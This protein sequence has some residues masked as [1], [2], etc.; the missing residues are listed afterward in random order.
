MGVDLEK[1]IA[2]LGG[3]GNIRR[4]YPNNVMLQ[5]EVTN[6]A[7]VDQAGI[8]AATGTIGSAPAGGGFLIGPLR[9]AEQTAQQIT[10]RMI[11]R[12]LGK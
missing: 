8:R 3:I 1:F 9:E 5:V 7:L 12:D 2:A 6:P 4:A 11:R 10:E